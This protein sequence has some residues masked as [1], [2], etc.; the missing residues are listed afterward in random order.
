MWQDSNQQV[1]VNERPLPGEVILMGAF[2]KMSDGMKL[3]APAS[4]L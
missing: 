2:L 3:A 1:T 4:C